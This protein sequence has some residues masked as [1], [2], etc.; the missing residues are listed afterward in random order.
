MIEAREQSYTKDWA[1]ETVS[2][3]ALSSIKG[4]GYWTLYK[5]ASQDIEFES[6]VRDSNSS[7]EFD[8]YF[9]KVGARPPKREE[10]WDEFQQVLWTTGNRLFK[11]LR[12]ANIRVRHFNEPTFPEKL[13]RIHEPPRWLFIQG[14]EELL[15]RKSIAIV[16]TRKPTED[17]IFLAKY[18]GACV[19]QF[20]TATISG[21]ASGIDQII[22]KQ[23]IRFKVP[24]VAVLGTGIF[25]NYPAG[26]DIPR[27]DILTHGGAIV[28][29]YLPYQSYS[30]QNFV[31]RNRIQAGL[32]EIVIPAQWRARSGTAHTVRY[33]VE[34]EKKVLCL[35]LPEDNLDQYDWIS[36]ADKLNLQIFTIPGEESRLVAALSEDIPRMLPGSYSSRT[37]INEIQDTDIV[38]ISSSQ[39]SLF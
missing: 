32:A 12:I 33:A 14:N 29:E 8:S 17:G 37:P 22:H 1:R 28:T 16:G 24:T 31:R 10:K 30:S 21:L 27:N 6:I 4:V 7:E 36:L 35:R 15:H 39:L 9:D 23:S 18:I 13:K 20:D 25:L 26:S 5:I 19:R 2:F 38:D 34:G 11:D 3:L